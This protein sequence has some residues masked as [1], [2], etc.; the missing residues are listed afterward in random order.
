[1]CIGGLP[2]YLKISVNT[3]FLCFTNILVRLSTSSV[4]NIRHTRL[5]LKN[6]H[7]VGYGFDTMEQS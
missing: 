4:V 7:I 3:R 5:R 1:M 6:L 2:S